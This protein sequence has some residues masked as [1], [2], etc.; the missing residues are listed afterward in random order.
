MSQVYIVR[1]PKNHY[2]YNLGQESMFN[3]DLV[4]PHEL[5]FQEPHMTLQGLSLQAHPYYVRRRD[6]LAQRRDCQ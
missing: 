4:Q 1:L 6:K 3:L 2:Y 5:I